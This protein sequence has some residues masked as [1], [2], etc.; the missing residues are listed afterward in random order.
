MTDRSE[1]GHIG[2]G[3][4]PCKPFKFNS[5]KAPRLGAGPDAG[6]ARPGSAGGGGRGRDVEAGAAAA[7]HGGGGRN[8]LGEGG[9]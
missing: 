2:A 9:A 7:E 1:S 6:P 5:D 4:A 3:P 8:G